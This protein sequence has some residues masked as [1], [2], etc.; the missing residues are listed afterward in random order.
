MSDITLASRK[1]I[2]PLTHVKYPFSLA[3]VFS[4]DQIITKAME[5][6]QIY[7]NHKKFS[8]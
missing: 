8:G 5:L 4:S 7:S 1:P 3:L 2:E 6:Q